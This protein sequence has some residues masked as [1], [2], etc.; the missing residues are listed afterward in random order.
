MDSDALA[1]K[2]NGG[3]RQMHSYVSIN[4][5]FT[6]PTPADDFD[7]NPNKLK[8]GELKIEDLQKQRDMDISNISYRN[9]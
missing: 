7:Y 2:G 8:E 1:S 4:D 3:L 6:I 9:T 5:N